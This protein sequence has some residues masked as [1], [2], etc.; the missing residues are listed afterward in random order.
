V[1]ASASLDKVLS[2][3]KGEPTGLIPVLQAVQRRLGYL[4]KDAL[5]RVA[6]HCRVPESTV[7]GVASFYQQFHLSRQ[8]RHS[9]KVCLGTGCHVRGGARVMSA[10]QKK[11]GIEPGETTPDYKFTLEKVACFGACALSPVIMVDGKIYGNMTSA[12]ASKLIGK[13]K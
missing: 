9:I 1:S 10:I 2:D 7:F 4:P 6:R 5:R 13:L 12:K 3:F 8:G 11:L